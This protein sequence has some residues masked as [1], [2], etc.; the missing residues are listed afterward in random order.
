MIPIPEAITIATV[1]AVVA[2]LE[3]AA[4]INRHED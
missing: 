1:L 3:L 4:K 2:V